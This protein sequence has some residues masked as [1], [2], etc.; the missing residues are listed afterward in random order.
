MI[1]IDKTML[2]F[3]E[4]VKDMAG[5]NNNSPSFFIGQITNI[6]PLRIKFN[7]IDLVEE[8][9][10]FTNSSNTLRDSFNQGELVLILVQDSGTIIL[11]DKVVK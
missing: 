6:K 7:N 8:Q 10:M 5:G 9:L 3:E 4:M 11:L 2:D 1:I